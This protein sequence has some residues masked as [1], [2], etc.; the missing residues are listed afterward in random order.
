M[1]KSLKD[2]GFYNSP[3]GAMPD[4]YVKPKERQWKPWAV[5]ALKAIFIVI[6]IDGLSVLLFEPTFDSG[7]YTGFAVAYFGGI[8]YDNTFKEDNNV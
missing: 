4:G 2:F 8:A 6:I 5:W 7:W 3:K 1:F